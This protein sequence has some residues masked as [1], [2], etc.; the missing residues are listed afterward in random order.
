MGILDRLFG[1]KPAAVAIEEKPIEKE[2]PHGSMAPHWEGPEDFGKR[3]LVSSYVC[4][5]CGKTFSR[6]EGE[7]VMA[8]AVEVVRIDES[9]RK[10]AE[11]EAAKQH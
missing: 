2:C 1:R 5:G 8:A 3:D 11:E 4:D 10:T 7:R 6:E 9:L